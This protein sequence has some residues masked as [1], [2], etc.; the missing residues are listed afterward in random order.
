MLA[1]I[2]FILMAAVFGKLALFGLRMA[3]GLSRFLLTIVFMPLL[4]IGLVLQGLM[5][6]AFPALILVGIAALL[7]AGDA[8]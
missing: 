2:F 6:I 3:W 1:V 8:A 5:Y 4:L 7:E